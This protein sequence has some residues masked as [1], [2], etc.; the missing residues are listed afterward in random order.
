[1]TDAAQETK[2]DMM[3]GLEAIPDTKIATSHGLAA[4]ALNM[5]MKYHDINTVRD[6]ALYQQYKLEGKNM[7]PL[8]LD[9][10]FE[11]AIKI[12]HHLLGSSERIAAMIV[13]ALEHAVDEEKPTPQTRP[14]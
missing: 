12:E 6:G 8:H 3:D 4:I 10:I 14:L 2:G 13:D 11:T 7:S 9:M 1:M 5:S